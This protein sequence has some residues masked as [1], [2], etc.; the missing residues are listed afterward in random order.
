MTTLEALMSQSSSID[1]LVLSTVFEFKNSCI[2]AWLLIVSSILTVLTI[3]CIILI[4]NPFSFGYYW[5]A[6]TGIVGL[7]LNYFAMVWQ[8]SC[9]N[10]LAKVMPK[11]TSGIILG[12]SGKTI[13]GLSWSA[14]CL[15][16]LATIGQIYIYLD[17]RNISM[18]N[19]E[20]E[21]AIQAGA[22]IIDLR[23][24][25]EDLVEKIE[26]QILP[27]HHHRTGRESSFRMLPPY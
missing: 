25:N 7:L 6:L 24:Q 17:D 11:I 15:L 5:S 21:Q 13:A 4:K 1:A 23:P 10:T 14:T 22:P 19:A 18:A 20:A 9:V 8:Q 2:S 26:D 27:H 12:K 3:F 16:T